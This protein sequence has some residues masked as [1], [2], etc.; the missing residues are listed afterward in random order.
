MLIEQRHARKSL[1]ALATSVLLD[2]AVCLHMGPQVRPIGESSRANLTFERL[3][4]GV[5]AH[6]TL[7]QPRSAETLAADLAFARQRVRPDV[8]F[9]RTK[10]VVSLVAVFARELLL[11]LSAA[12]ELLVLRKSPESRITLIAVFAL[13]ARVGK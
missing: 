8:H 2:V 13:V 4:A 9:E 6:M 1:V 11:N 10:R 5:R 12:V 3:F 7:Q